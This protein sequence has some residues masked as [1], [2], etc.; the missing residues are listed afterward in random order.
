MKN[1]T[2]LIL[3]FFLSTTLMHAQMVS[4]KS[5]PNYK[6]WGWNAI[7]MQND[8]IT[9]ATVPAIGARVMQYDLGN[10]PSVYI[11]SAELGNTYTPTQNV[12][13]HLFG[14]YKTWP[15]PQNNWS[16][17]GWPPPPT[18]DFGTYTVTDSLSTKDSVY[19]VVE[20]QI[21]KWLSPGIQ[22]IRKQRCIPEAVV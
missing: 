3:A 21:E 22:F 4:L 15:S 11:N 6:Q 9:I 7:V 8:F 20:S 13:L 5:I 12:Q 10:L 1:I 19:L 18:L 2:A 14:G 17:G 16:N